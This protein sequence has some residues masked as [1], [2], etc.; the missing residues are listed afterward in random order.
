MTRFRLVRMLVLAFVAFAT[1]SAFAVKAQPLT[2]TWQANY[3]S[4]GVYGDA[5]DGTGVYDHNVGGVRCYFGVNERNIVLVTY[6]TGRKLHFKFDPASS[7]PESAGLPD[8][9]LAEVDLFGINYFGP[10]TS[11]GIGTTAQV[12]MDLEF[13]MPNNPLTYELDYSSLAVVRLDAAT[14]RITSQV[15]DVPSLIVTPSPEAKLNVV[16]RRSAET[17]GTVNMPIRFEV[18]LK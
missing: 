9:F 11:M 5:S 10:Y 16:R 8:D 1:P 2:C 3:F 18:K 4:I 13:H 14:W 15:A 12:Q 6:N 17:F 7:V